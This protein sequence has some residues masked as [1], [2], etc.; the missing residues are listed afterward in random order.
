MAK[1]QVVAIDIGTATIKIV[2]I[3]KTAGALHLVNAGIMPCTDPDNLQQTAEVVKQ[4][5]NQLGIKQNIFNK[6]QLEIAISLPRSFVVTKRLSN[7][8]P[9]TPDAQIPSMVAMAA[10]TE[11]P[12]QPEEA[13]FTYHDIQRTAEAVSVE[14]VSTRRETV[15]RYMEALNSIG[16]SPSAVIPSMLA[17]ATA[18]RNAL[19]D[20]NERTVIVDVGANRTD[21]CLMHGSNL[22][23]S[24]SF[25]VGGKQL[26]QQIMS[27]MQ[28]EEEQADQ[29]KQHIPAHQA[30]TRTWTRSFVAELERSI[31]AAQREISDNGDVEISEI[32]L[33][34]GGA[35]VPELVETCHE[36]LQIP[37]KLWNPIQT[38]AVD[39]DQGTTS[40]FA[41]DGDCF[42]VPLGVGIHLLD[43]EQ[44][45]SLL[46]Q[47]VGVKRAESTRKRQQLVAAGI[48][49][50][51]LIVLALGGVTWSR[52]QE[53]KEALLDS[54]IANFEKSQTD[55][56]KQLA[57]EL[58]LADKLT[59]QISPL[60]ILHALSTLFKDRTKVAWKTFEV[61]NLDDLAKTRISFSLQASSHP[62]INSMLGTLGNS[63]IF[64]R[65]EPGEVTVTG[66]ERRPT[67][68]VK[69]NCQLT[70]EA[71]QMFAQKRHP[72]P[73][74]EM[75]ETETIE[76]LP[77]DNFEPP[78][79]ENEK[80]EKDE[81]DE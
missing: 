79:K 64:S 11:L 54:Q 62:A 51:A 74:I 49:G 8:P 46:P 59:H 72:K 44:P 24:R 61:R 15:T 35:R 76:I 68:E 36:Q 81:K 60:D 5:W 23:F 70:Q 37:T 7:L 16:T 19:P 69:V 1:N 71:I 29:E 10:E 52:S 58:I 75:K 20:G 48:G 43:V 17:I 26:T 31:S 77:P 3:E 65:I 22:E 4:L 13:I 14:L 9:S 63:K 39:I 57:L 80:D 55:A 56:N 32:W 33:C 53:A 40:L 18:A 78:N 30:P 27:E 47:E 34:G 45:V 6:H 12:F 2:H 21:F 67:F 73:E 28:L 25:L 50:L 66:D 41:T 42:A 38:G